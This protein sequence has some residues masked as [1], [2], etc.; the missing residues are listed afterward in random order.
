MALAARKGLARLYPALPVVVLAALLALVP[1]PTCL[2]RL[3]L[4]IPCPACGLTRATLAAMR[5]DFGA[6]LRWHPLSLAL[7]AAIAVVSGAAFV[8]SDGTWRRMVVVTTGAAGV[9]LIVVWVMRFAG[10]FGGPVPG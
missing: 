10:W 2:L 6:A 1:F 3:A 9:L 5:L 4:G 8:A 7:L